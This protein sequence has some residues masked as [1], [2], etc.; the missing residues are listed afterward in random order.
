MAFSQKSASNYVRIFKLR[1]RG[2]LVNIT[3][4]SEAYGLLLNKENE[5]QRRD[6]RRAEHEA[7]VAELSL[8]GLAPKTEEAGPTAGP[9]IV[10][11]L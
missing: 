1:R 4:L 8:S 7:F 6:Q 10:D 3:N 9:L 2:K 11:W 5:G